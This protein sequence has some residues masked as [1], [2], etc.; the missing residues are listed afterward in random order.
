MS[1]D[2]PTGRDA[3]FH[4]RRF[5]PNSTARPALKLRIPYY[6][7][8]IFTIFPATKIFYV[9]FS[10]NVPSEFKWINLPYRI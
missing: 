8:T 5:L 9:L 10:F 3:F 7:V 2:A 6:T 4:A 1:L